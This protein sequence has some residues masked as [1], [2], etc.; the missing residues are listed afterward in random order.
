MGNVVSVLLDGTQKNSTLL[1]NSLN[2]WKRNA[3]KKNINNMTPAEVRELVIKRNAVVKA[4]CEK[5]GWF[6]DITK[7]KLSQQIE[8]RKLPE[9]KN[10]K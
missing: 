1:K 9:W 2:I 5:R 3:G 4:Y 10:P 6:P 8:I 7:L